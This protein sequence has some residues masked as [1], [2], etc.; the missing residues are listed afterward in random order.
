MKNIIAAAAL[1]FGFALAV[2]GVNAAPLSAAPAASVDAKAG[3][4]ASENVTYRRHYRYRH[5]RPY[6]PRYYRPYYGWSFGY[7][8]PWRDCY[9]RYGR[10]V[11]VWRY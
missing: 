10:R 9:W 8:R 2:P 3:A 1:A 7:A 4:V 5:Y 11:C 6:R